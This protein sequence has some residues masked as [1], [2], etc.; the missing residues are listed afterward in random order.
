M[1]LF[2]TEIGNNMG[3]LALLERRQVHFL[4]VKF[5]L[6]RIIEMGTLK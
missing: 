2:F 5:E 6:C 3:K 1:Q 4:S